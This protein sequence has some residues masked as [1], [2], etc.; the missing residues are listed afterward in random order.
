M[1]AMASQIT[2]VSIV[3]STVC[4][5]AD[6][7]KKLSPASLACVSGIHR[8][9]MNSPH[10]GSVTRI[11][12]PF[13]DVI[14]RGC[15]SSWHTSHSKNTHKVLTRYL[16]IMT[17]F[18]HVWI[19]PDHIIQQETLGLETAM[20]SHLTTPISILCSA[21][22]LIILTM[23]LRSDGDLWPMPLINYV[24]KGASS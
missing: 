11:M 1:S 3:Y 21:G 14:M 10:N 4:S 2:G 22:T 16:W 24:W 7:R 13:D 17:M 5:G 12:F 6:Q 18:V 19:P 8:S 15:V 20:V 9:P 23:I